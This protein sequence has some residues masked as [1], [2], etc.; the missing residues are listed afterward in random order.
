MADDEQT[1]S[2]T[3]AIRCRFMKDDD[4]PGCRQVAT[5]SAR[6]RIPA[7]GAAPGIAKVLVLKAPSW[8]ELPARGGGHDR[9]KDRNNHPLHA[10]DC[11]L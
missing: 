1:I 11:S 5:T 9:E 8:L 3:G 7:P 6:G 2:K 10:H 4:A